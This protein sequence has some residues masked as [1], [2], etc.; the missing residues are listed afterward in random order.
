MARRTGPPGASAARNPKRRSDLTVLR[1]A[2]LRIPGAGITSK[3]HPP[4]S[5]GSS[6]HCV[7]VMLELYG[8][9]TRAWLKI[10]GGGVWAHPGAGWLV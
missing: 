9:V 8:R 4:G 1:S 5:V 7:V 2:L 3:G 10:V 6:I